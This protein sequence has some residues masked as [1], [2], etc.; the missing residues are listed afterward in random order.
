MSMEL[1]VMDTKWF[2]KHWNFEIVRATSLHPNL[3]MDWH[4]AF[5]GTSPR[6]IQPI[7]TNRHRR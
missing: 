4:G 6:M 1:I 5:V 7:A 3:L 2:T